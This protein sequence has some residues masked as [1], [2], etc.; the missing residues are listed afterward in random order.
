MKTN[1]LSYILI[2]FMLNSC[3]SI[4]SSIN[5]PI[6]TPKGYE[7]ILNSWMNNDVNDLI[8]SWGP[9]VDKYVMPNG[10]AMYT[11]LYIGNTY[12][13]SNYNQYLNQI[14]SYAYTKYCKTTFTVSPDNK[15]VQWRYQGNLC[16]AYPKK[17]IAD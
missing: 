7:D 8:Q 2:I 15:I 17:D 1:H 6:P 14:N 4:M 11:W 13:T 9:P 5:S 10:N 12:V 16:R 3:A